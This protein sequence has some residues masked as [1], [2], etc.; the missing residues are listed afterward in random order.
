M[1]NSIKLGQHS[2]GDVVEQKWVDQF[3]GILPPAW[4]S[5]DLIQLGEVYTFTNGK[6]VYQTLKITDKGWVYAGI[7]FLGSSEN[8]ISS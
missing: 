2:I 4:N 7:C 5:S 1:S 6:A 3:I 8:V